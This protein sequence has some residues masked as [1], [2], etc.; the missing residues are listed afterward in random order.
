MTLD[1]IHCYGLA[2]IPENTPGMAGYA[3]TKGGN[4]I[5][6]DRISLAEIS[7]LMQVIPSLGTSMG[8]VMQQLGIP[9]MPG[10]GGMEMQGDEFPA[11]DALPTTDEIPRGTYSR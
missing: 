1:K 10:A 3:L 11:Q 7:A 9:G 4:L 8:P 6:M 5:G 2:A